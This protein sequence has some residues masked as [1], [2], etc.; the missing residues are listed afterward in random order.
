MLTPTSFIVPIVHT[1][2][3]T[4][5]GRNGILN[6]PSDL[7][8]THHLCLFAFPPFSAFP[9]PTD[10]SEP[11]SPPHAATLVRTIDMPSFHVDLTRDIPP[12]RMNIRADPPPRAEFPTHP[13]ENVQAFV[14]EPTSGTY[15]IEFACQTPD[16]PFPH[17]VMVMPKSTLLQ[18]VPP[19][20]SPLLRQ[21]RPKPM[22]VVS[23][24]KFRHDVRLF[25]HEMIPSCKSRP[26]LFKD[27]T[28][29][30]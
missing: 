21:A 28:S 8:W 9:I 17:Y 25:G 1:R 22:P 15:T 16:V 20:D 6:D 11:V 19:K 3:D 2:L 10:P 29:A 7:S 18:H 5:S 30:L 12:P 13:V 26:T 4:A 14:P 23:W 24:D 27:L